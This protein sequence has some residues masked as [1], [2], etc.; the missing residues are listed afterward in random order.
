[1]AD[2][3][4]VVGNKLYLLG[5]GWDLLTVNTGFP[6]EQRC[7]IAVSV[8]VPWNETNQRHTFEIEVSEDVPGTEA[9]RSLV[10]V[11]GQFEV[12]RPPGIPLGSDQRIQ[13]AIDM[14]LKIEA[15]GTKVVKARIEEQPMREIRFNVIPGP[16][17][18]T[19]PNGGG[20]DSPSG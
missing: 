2:A 19:K 15:S 8:K 16:M 9:P 18:A 4:Q 10:K 14:N 20:R 13:L 5:G 12:G 3:A 1:M 11:G 17:L 7:A 6:I